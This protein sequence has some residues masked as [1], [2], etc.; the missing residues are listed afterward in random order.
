MADAFPTHADLAAALRRVAAFDT[1]PDEALADMAAQMSVAGLADGDILVRQDDAGARL[2]VVLSG[3]IALT[4]SDRQGVQRALPDVEPGATFGEI[5]AVM[6]APATATA[7]ARGTTI[8][9]ALSRSG[10]E[11]FA[12]TWPAQAFEFLEALRPRLYR[13]RLQLSLRQSATFRTVD[14]A[15]LAELEEVCDLV[16]L[17]SGE[18]LLRQGDPGDSLYLVVSGR[19]RVVR[20]V[21]GRPDVVLAELGAGETVGEMALISGEPRSADVYAIRDTQLARLTKVAFEKVLERHPKPTFTMMA[22]GLVT[23]IRN[24]SAGIRGNSTLSTVAVVP[25]SPGAPLAAFAGQLADALG[26]LGPTLLLSSQ[27]VDAQLG[28]AGASQAYDRDGGSSRLL[29][30]LAGQEL[31]HRFV[32]YQSDALCSPWTERCVRQADQI[33]VVADATA[34]PAPGEIET[35]VVSRGPAGKARRLLALVH[36][37]G[38]QPS[39]TARWLTGRAIDRHLHLHLGDT[40]DFDRLA[41][42]M[43]GTAVGLALGGGFARGLAHLGVLRALEELDIAIDVI[44]GSS[45]GGIVGGMWALGRSPVRIVEEIATSFAKSFDDMTMPFLSFKRGGGHSRA[46]R[47]FFG[48]TQIEDLWIP[49]FCTSANL[50]R[51]ELKVHML[52]SLATATLASSRAPG[53]FP[54]VVIDGELHVDGGLINNTPVDVMRAFSNDGIV[55]GVGVSPPHELNLVKDYGHDISGWQAMWHRFNPTRGNRVYHPSILLVL[56]R[57]IELGGVSYGRE[58]A[59]VA[60]LYIEPD[61]LP[62]KRNDFHR[63]AEMADVGHAATREALLAWLAAGAERYGARR[64]DLFLR[65]EPETRIAHTA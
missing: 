56:M 60:D 53:I 26:K 55:I 62:F 23:R 15:V 25:A 20:R 17:Y 45:M 33:V 59:N 52:G 22:G 54:P 50:N 9:A 21:P 57:V 48:D 1:L 37:P 65:P 14:P 61:L 19:I 43:T 2:C 31:E 46:I 6:D 4:Y 32:I 51:S 39:R 24:M 40:R 36:P 10:V 18:T 44:G 49:Y 42:L 13:H 35:D 12:E 11:R 28:L 38:A 7:R 63:A 41:R 34:D 64:P 30:L 58:K 27:R 3:A 8:V 47:G 5:N 16:P 29:E